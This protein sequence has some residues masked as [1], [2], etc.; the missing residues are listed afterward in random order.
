MTQYVI[1]LDVG[2]TTVKCGIFE[3][4]GTLVKKWETPTNKEEGSVHLF[5]DLAASVKEVLGELEIGLHE[6]KG[7]GMGVP[8]PITEDGY[9]SLLTN[10]GLKDM[11]PGNV[12][13]EL[14]DGVCCKVGNDANVAALGEMWK[15]GAKGY[16][17]VAMLTLGTG[18]G[19][20]IIVDGKVIAGMHG[21]GGEVG[22]IHVSDTLVD[23]C[24]C[25]CSGCLEQ[26][27][28]ATGIVNSARRNMMKSDIVSLMENYGSGLTAKDVCDC[29]KQG[30]V[31]AIITVDECCRAIGRGLATIAYTVDPEV[32]VIGGGVSKAGSW[33][34]E[35]IEKYYRQFTPLSKEKALVKL[36]ELGNDAGIY[37]AAKLVL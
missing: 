31:V 23:H 26:L 33:L 27:G 37:G 6:V 32:F 35:Q 8:G 25:G 20:G 1:G 36:A 13:S 21:V 5:S 34:I 4:D 19:G 24:N 12:M 11:Y 18:V 22:H 16:S 17:N 9:V 10:L 28:S 30:D 14:L 29:A 2:G 15:G 7:V 3:L